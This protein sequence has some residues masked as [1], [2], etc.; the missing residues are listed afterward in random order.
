MSGK[1]S[2]LFILCCIGL[3]AW[4]LACATY[5]LQNPDAGSSSPGARPRSSA[6]AVPEPVG[7]FDGILARNLLGVAVSPPESAKS[8]AGD[9]E[10]PSPEESPEGLPMSR[11]GWK[12]LGTIVDNGG[13]SRAIIEQNGR[14]QTYREGE[15]LQGWKIARIQRRM[16]VVEQGGS[17]ERLLMGDEE[18]QKAASP[19]A[20]GKS[21]SRERLRDQLGDLGKLMRAVTVAPQAIGGYRGLRIVSIQPGSYME[22]LGLKKEDLLLGANGK[23]LQGFGDLTGLG[24]LADKDAITLEIL[25]NGKKTIIRYDVRS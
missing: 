23:P 24:D 18:P 17:R 22:E 3:C 9:T 25:R 12:L 5:L 16:I 8:E 13:Q 4:F 11:R 2:T 20:A 19:A 1:L 15:S 14:E 7:V 6:G 21:L 10:T